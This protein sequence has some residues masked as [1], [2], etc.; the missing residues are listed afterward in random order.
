MFL[1]IILDKF[2]RHYVAPRWRRIGFDAGVQRL[3]VLVSHNLGDA[4][5]EGTFL[6]ALC[7]E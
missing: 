2:E 5:S 6:N 3:Y 1:L 7:D 4:E